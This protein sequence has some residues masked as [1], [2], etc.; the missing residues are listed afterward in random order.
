MNY[1]Q[2]FNTAIVGLFSFDGAGHIN[3]AKDDHSS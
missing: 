3:V 1:N 2:L